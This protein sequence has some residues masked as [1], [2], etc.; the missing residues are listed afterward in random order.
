MDVILTHEQADFDGISAM[1]GAYLLQEHAVAILPRQLN[2]NV[3]DFLKLYS[4]EL[5]FTKANELPKEKIDSVTLVDTQS[6]VT[7][8]GMHDNTNVFVLDH[9]Q[10]RDDFPNNWVFTYIP[11]G[12]STTYFIEDIREQNGKL[13]MIQA[14]LLLLG[15][16][17]DTG[18]LIYPNT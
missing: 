7:L 13:T 14:T 4:A 10:K 8:K 15:I 5:P 11:T 3:Q 9:H 18:S 2:R 6:L 12:A 17:E 16:Y 1:L